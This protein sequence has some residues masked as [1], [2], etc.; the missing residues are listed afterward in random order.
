MI[1]NSTD[2]SNYS[3]YNKIY[4]P[5]ELNNSNY[6]YKISDDHIIV[7]TNR[8][9]YTQ[10]NSTYC[11]CYYYNYKNNLTSSTY[12][13]NTNNSST[14]LNYSSISSDINDSVYLSNRF[15]QDKSILLFVI[16]LALIFARF[17]TKERS[18]I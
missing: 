2:I 4:I 13:C 15:Y 8:N 14:S 7:I 17:L 10:Y 12:T 11:D 1:K 3:N 5:S 16:I 9:C 6:Q 18:H